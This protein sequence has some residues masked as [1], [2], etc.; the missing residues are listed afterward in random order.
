PSP[1]APR[2]PAPGRET[3]VA[4]DA[5]NQL[6]GSGIYS[7]PSR[8]RSDDL[9]ARSA[10]CAPLG[11]ASARLAGLAREYRL[12]R[13]AAPSRA[14]PFPSAEVVLPARRCEERATRVSEL[15]GVIRGLPAVSPDFLRRP[16]ET[17]R[18][19]LAGLVD[20]DRQLFSYTETVSELCSWM[21][22][23]ALAQQGWDA[24]D[25]A[26]ESLDLAIKARQALLR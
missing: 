1:V 2:P 18:G 8:L 7:E 15:E 22:L 16:P 6:L 26:L 13:V 23:D 10:A 3:T 17:V 20:A 21:T 25:A 14:N 19:L 11:E 12:T 4:R 24:L 5:F 9:A